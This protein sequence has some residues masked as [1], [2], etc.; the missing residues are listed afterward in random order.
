MRMRTAVLSAVIVSLGVGV[1]CKKPAPVVDTAAEEAKRKAAEEEARR[2]AEEEARLKRE[3]EEAERR[4]LEEEARKRKEAEEAALRKAQAEEYRKSLEAAT[5][6]INF[7]YDKFAIRET[8]KTKLQTLADFLKKNVTVK[9]LIEGHCD[10]R[11]TTEYNMVL[12]GK[13]ASAT[14]AYLVT[15]GVAQDR[16]TTLS[17]GKEMPKVQ[18]KDEESYLI[19]RRAEFKIQ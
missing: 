19:N 13:R 6:D 10:E 2:K 5:R 12:G 7:D 8:D 11:G 15:L 16:L 18:G 3:A 17:K 14:Q 9:I 4:R 1:A